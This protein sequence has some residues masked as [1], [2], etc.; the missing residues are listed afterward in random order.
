[1]KKKK[2]AIACQGGGSQTAFT[3]GVLK[4]FFDHDVHKHNEIVSLSG[5]SGGA[6][7]AALAWYSLVGSKKGDTV[8]MAQPL[9]D[10][11]EDNSTRDVFEEWYNDFWIGVMRLIDAG[12]MARWE[13]SPAT[14]LYSLLLPEVTS[15]FPHKN[16]YDI[17]KLLNTHIDFSLIEKWNKPK[18][19]ASPALLVGAV[20]VLRGEF[21]RFSSI[22]GEISLDSIL[23]ST[24][25]P[26]LYPAV[27]VGESVYWD[28]LFS[29]NPPTDELLDRRLVGEMNLPDELWVI[30]INPK[31][32]KTMPLSP[33][34]IT[35]RRNE[36]IGNQSLFHD[37]EKIDL[38]N[39]FLSDGA[40]TDKYRA[41]YRPVRIRIVEM[42]KGMQEKLDYA[43]KLDRNRRRIDMLIADGE[44]QGQFFLKQMD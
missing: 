28:G 1:M 31:K 16:F 39:R 22:R 3:A 8:P 4:S 23:A 41:K 30:Q 24:A 33:D 40:F 25:V 9:M 15:L 34:D 5:T 7:C 42:S 20:D 18:P 19:P 27:P 12:M 17:K 35:D 21:K 36:L 6:I 32:R 44:T 43:S 29:D 11:W 14:N 13:T 38:I 37:L 2:I 10:F 26:A